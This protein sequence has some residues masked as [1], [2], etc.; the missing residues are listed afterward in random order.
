MY[1]CCSVMTQTHPYPFILIHTVDSPC[2]APANYC[3]WSDE[4]SSTCCPVRTF[5]SPC[6][7]FLDR[8][9]KM[10]SLKLLFLKAI[11][12]RPLA[13]PHVR[14]PR[15]HK[16]CLNPLSTSPNSRAHLWPT[17]NDAVHLRL[18]NVVSWDVGS[19][20]SWICGYVLEMNWTRDMYKCIVDY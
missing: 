9:L 2:E 20:I 16:W 15:S 6:R 3:R 13:Y 12:S 7:A 18:H 19:W 4:L 10:T 11:F 5:L 17:S 8:P 1:L 14:P